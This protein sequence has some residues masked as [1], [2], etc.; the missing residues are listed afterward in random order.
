MV[1]PSF[2]TP[3]HIFD[4]KNALVVGGTYRLEIEHLAT[5]PIDNS[6]WADSSVKCKL[7]L[8]DSG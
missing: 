3:R 1:L 7:Q 4:H 8:A 5:C 2:P 6:D